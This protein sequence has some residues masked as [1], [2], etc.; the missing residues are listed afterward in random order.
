MGQHLLLQFAILELVLG[1]GGGV[2]LQAGGLI[3]NKHREWDGWLLHI[4]VEHPSP[5]LLFE[6]TH[7]QSYVFRS[8]DI[9]ELCDSCFVDG[10][11]LLE[12]LRL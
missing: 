8:N 6:P 9:F 1:F 7:K 4:S 2:L 10:H 5:V 11:E 12:L 3:L